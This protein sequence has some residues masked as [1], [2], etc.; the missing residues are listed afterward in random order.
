MAAI[1]PIVINDAATTPVAHSFSPVSILGD[2]SKWADRV[3]GIAIGYPVITMS[4]R[5]PT[6]TSRM[7]KV[8]ARVVTPTLEQTSPS[9]A[10]GIQPAPT[11]AYDCMSV[12]EHILPERSTLQQRKDHMAFSRGFNNGAVMTAAV[13]SFESVY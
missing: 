1:A 6:K 9:T 11:K 4:L 5:A 3:T 10:T 13:E 12:Y 2:L 8:S 7:Y